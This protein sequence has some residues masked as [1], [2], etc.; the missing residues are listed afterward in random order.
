MRKII[1][2]MFVSL[3]GVM[4]G[5]GSADNFAL[6]GWTDPYWDDEVGKGGDEG[7][8]E[9]TKDA[10]PGPGQGLVRAGS[11]RMIRLRRTRVQRFKDQ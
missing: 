6:A 10:K 8:R 9:D 7:H 5:P 4:E 1:V 2:G 11:R 3:D